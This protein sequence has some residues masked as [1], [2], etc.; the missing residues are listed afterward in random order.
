MSGLCGIVYFKDTFYLLFY[1]HLDYITYF[2]L[3]M[4]IVAP[5]SYIA[6]RQ[7]FGDYDL[8]KTV[9]TFFAM[10]TQITGVEN[11]AKRIRLLLICSL[12]YHMIVMICIFF[13]YIEIGSHL[14]VAQA[15]SPIMNF[16]L[17]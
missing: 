15:V 6:T 9:L 10:D 11:V 4:A 16:W 8:K 12:Q 1:P 3:M 7:D 2:L 13:D 5:I 14:N 17:W